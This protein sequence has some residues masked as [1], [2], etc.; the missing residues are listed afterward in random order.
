[1]RTAVAALAA[2]AAAVVV[3]L[4]NPA[5]AQQPR[6]T[7][8]SSLP[9]RGAQAAQAG[10]MVRGMRLAL[11]RAGGR[12]GATAIRYVSLDDS[13]ARAGSWTPERASA[14]A[15]R[16]TRDRT[17]LAYLGEFNSGAT[18][19][20]LPILNE[21]GVL[22]ISPSNTAVGL[23]RGGLGADRGEPAK[24][25]PSGRRTFGRIAAPDTVQGAAAGALLRELG[26][27]RV[28]VLHDGELYGRGLARIAARAARARGLR[29]L[30][31]RRVSPVARATDLREVARDVRRRRADAVFSGGVTSNGA[32]ALRQALHRQVPRT[33][34]VAGDGV[35][36]S[37]FTDP[38][39]GGI[40]RAAARRTRILLGTLAPAAYP[41][42]GQEVL[43]A[44]GPG[45]DP[46]ALH[47]YEAMSLALDA[48]ARGGGTRAGAIDALF[49]T[50]DRDSVLGRYSI[51][52]FGDPT[53]TRYGVYRVRRGELVFERVVQAAAP[54]PA[55]GAR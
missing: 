44:L 42:A 7:I 30:A 54:S 18:A 55:G 26:A 43:T 53:I 47:G 38:R 24:Y 8:Y 12:A 17:A 29:V 28:Y 10:A 32:A 16:A 39:E 33:P 37:T 3:A 52:R 48:I 14:N 36:G 13:T 2:V 6:G 31:T 4:A 34:F 49:A 1:M 35:A 9:L 50:R 23:T 41:A 27:R 22:Q 45:T 19:I 11:Q 46:Y 21:A 20:S 5:A 40:G 25:Y 15:R 51:D